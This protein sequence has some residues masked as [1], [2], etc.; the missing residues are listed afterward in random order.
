MQ[1]QS[2]KFF[3]ALESLRGIAALLVVFYHIGWMYPLYNIEL[4]RNG[5]LMVDLFFVLSGFVMVHSYGSKL[6]EK[7]SF[8]K[9]I[10]ARFWRIYPLH[11]VFLI[12]FLGIEVAKY[13]AETQL[14]L[15]SNNPAFS[16][17]NFESFIYHLLLIHSMGFQ[18]QGSFNSPSWSISVEFYAYILFAIT[19]ILFT[20][21]R[22]RNIISLCIVIFSLVIICMVGQTSLTF[23]YN[24]SFFRC[25]YGFF[26]GVLAGGI[27][28]AMSLKRSYTL[29]PVMEIITTSFL[30]LSIAY[31]FSIKH[32]NYLEFF[33]PPLIAILIIFLA[34]FPS[35]SL[36]KILDWKPFLW[37]GKVSY[38]IY[39]THM[40]FIWSFS[41]VLKVV[42]DIKV[43]PTQ[44]DVLMTSMMFGT[45]TTIFLI[46]CVLLC[47]Y[48]TFKYIEDPFRKFA[49][50]RQT[51]AS[52]K[53]AMIAKL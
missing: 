47:S 4:F 32:D 45:I 5:A 18:E 11:F 42:F 19:I 36:S 52:N 33:A 53:I 26:I 46:A 49:R 44:V 31:L 22:S 48:F 12:V 15:N 9:F 16:K 29:K 51:K 13:I 1:N 28:K 37:L 3:P 2:Q 43:D 20:T 34:F 38:S 10:F 39:M 35:S 30:F 27:F 14:A 8:K 24:Y 6:G 17:S 41:A 40:A 23:D 7:G 50:K 21:D 25:T